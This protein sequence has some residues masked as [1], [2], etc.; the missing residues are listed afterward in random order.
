MSEKTLLNTGAPQV[1]D[2]HFISEIMIQTCAVRQNQLI[3]WLQWTIF[4][5][6]D[7]PGGSE[8][9]ELGIFDGRPDERLPL[10]LC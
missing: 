10:S 6:G 7:V 2:L 3:K 9:K 8:N 1:F 4:L 5:K